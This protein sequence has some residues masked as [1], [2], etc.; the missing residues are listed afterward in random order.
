MAK[1][2]G[3]EFVSGPTDTLGNVCFSQS[4]ELR[5]D[6]K[7]TFSIIDLLD[8]GY[9]RLH[10]APHRESLKEFLKTDFPNVPFKAPYPP[11]LNKREKAQNRFWKLVRLGGELRQIHLLESPKVNHFITSYPKDGDNQIS[12]K[13]TK[14]SP[15]YEP[16]TKTHGKVWIN[17]VQYFDQVPRTA[18]EFYIGGYRP[19]HKWL[20][21]RYGSELS[22]E[23]IL[24][25]QK[26]IVALTETD[27][28]MKEIDSIELE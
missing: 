11:S 26:I 10:S 15:G 8:Y 5:D 17:D 6:Y 4:P 14:T 18:W 13:L 12:R 16:S 25:Y 9:A 28:I 2:L 1:D 7:T 20:E 21:D 27:R 24:D 23:D 19:A 22:F 3:L